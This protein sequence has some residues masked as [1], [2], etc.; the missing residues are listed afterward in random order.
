MA[1]LVV[2]VGSVASAFDIPDAVYPKLSQQAASA[3]SFVPPGWKL[4]RQVAGDLNR[5][6]VADLVLLLRETNPKNMV[7]HDIL[8]ENPLDT[9]PRILA[10]AFGSRAGPYALHLQN[11]TLIPRREIPA[12]SD[13]LDENDLAIDRDVLRMKLNYFTSAGSWMS[14]NTTCRLRFVN[15]RFELIGFDRDTFNR[16]TGETTG[17][18]VNFLTGKV[19]TTAGTMENE[20]QKVRWTKLRKR[21]PIALDRV[22]SCLDF[23]P[24]R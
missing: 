17:L 20:A 11:H 3:D 18:S 1:L 14:H 23:D 2:G 22:G 4:E 21:T 13:P 19:Q 7:E 10:I 16:A 9:N 12:V 15:D 8:G 24:P 6:G 5:D